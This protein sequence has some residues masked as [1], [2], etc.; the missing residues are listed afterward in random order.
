MGK[1]GHQI[2]VGEIRV[3]YLY[4]TEK[5]FAAAKKLRQNI[6]RLNHPIPDAEKYYKIAANVRLT[7]NHHDL[8]NRW[9]YST[10]H[11]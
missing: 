10:K 3:D 7:S 6:F 11:R 4:Q 9:V 1:A 5:E 2:V 8:E